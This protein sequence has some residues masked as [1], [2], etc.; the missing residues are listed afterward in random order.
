MLTATTAVGS[1][2]GRRVY[3]GALSPQISALST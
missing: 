3:V 1:D 2:P